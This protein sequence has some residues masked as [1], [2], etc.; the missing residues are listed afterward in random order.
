MKR[1]MEHTKWGR[2]DYLLVWSV[3][4]LG[5]L[6][7]LYELM[8]H[9]MKTQTF[10]AF[11][12]WVGLGTAEPALAEQ[13]PDP[14]NPVTPQFLSKPYLSANDKA[15]ERAPVYAE[16]A[17]KRD[18]FIRIDGYFLTLA[19][20]P[21]QPIRP[22]GFAA[23]KDLKT[24]PTYKIDNKF[25]NLTSKELRGSVMVHVIASR[26]DS[27]AKRVYPLVAMDGE[28]IANADINHKP[29]ERKFE[30]KLPTLRYRVLC[31]DGYAGELQAG[32]LGVGFPLTRSDLWP[33]FKMTFRP[34]THER[35]GIL[36]DRLDSV[37][38][39]WRVSLDEKSPQTSHDVS[40]LLFRRGAEGMILP[41]SSVVFDDPRNRNDIID[42]L[43]RNELTLGSLLQEY[44]KEKSLKYPAF[45]EG[46]AF[47]VGFTP[48]FDS[49]VP[50]IV[51]RDASPP[52]VPGDVDL[53]ARLTGD[54]IVAASDN[55]VQQVNQDPQGNEDQKGGQEIQPDTFTYFVTSR[56]EIFSSAPVQELFTSDYS[57][58]MSADGE[59][60]V[61]EKSGN[62]NMYKITC[63]TQPQSLTI[64]ALAE[65]ILAEPYL[66]D[67]NGTPLINTDDPDGDGPL[68]GALQT[69]AIRIVHTQDGVE[70]SELSQGWQEVSDATR[71]LELPPGP[72]GDFTGTLV[73]DPRTAPSTAPGL[74]DLARAI[75]TPANHE[76]ACGTDVT[77]ELTLDM[78]IA[79]KI[80]VEGGPCGR[81]QTV[82]LG[83]PAGLMPDQ[84]PV[85]TAQPDTGTANCTRFDL[86]TASLTCTVPVDTQTIDL[87]GTWGDHFTLEGHTARLTTADAEGRIEAPSI[88]IRL[89]P[90]SP[91]GTT[92]DEIWDPDIPAPA[93]LRY[94]PTKV[95]Y[96]TSDGDV[97]KT[98][99]LQTVPTL[100]AIGL[101]CE[102]LPTGI[103][104]TFIQVGLPEN[105][106]QMWGDLSAAFKGE[107]V[108]TVTLADPSRIDP[109]DV[110]K[111][112]NL[113]V[114][115]SSI[116]EDELPKLAGPALSLFK[117]DQCGSNPR[118]SA[119]RLSIDKN[120]GDTSGPVPAGG[121]SALDP[122]AH[123]WPLWGMYFTAEAPGTPPKSVSDCFPARIQPGGTA[124]FADGLNRSLEPGVTIVISMSRDLAGEGISRAT[125]KALEALAA[126]IDAEKAAGRASQLRPI[127]VL[128]I[129]RGGTNPTV[130]NGASNLASATEAILSLGESGLRTFSMD[131]FEQ[132][133]RVD[134]SEGAD[135]I[136]ITEGHEYDPGIEY[137]Y[138][139]LLPENVSLVLNGSCDE[140][141]R[142]F[143]ED[144]GCTNISD[145]GGPAAIERHL[146]QQFGSLIWG[147][148]Q[149][150]F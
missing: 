24:P 138:V 142:R 34:H 16:C 51:S 49:W 95:E 71:L 66:S 123:R 68:Q 99:N 35:M 69:Q 67:L 126:A 9:A 23:Y 25:G 105:P 119:W 10:I 75:Q 5:V 37:T 110:Y 44:Q 97:C 38:A 121:S 144:V 63:N 29:K 118:D 116:S 73:I 43:N 50:F 94:H 88:G 132:D 33:S 78:A 120:D 122:A 129:D 11:L 100:D 28:S 41:K 58:S 90:N 18:Q 89:F 21:D 45:L 8:S 40:P 150:L 79:G 42:R 65:I 112:L 14:E 128:K 92:V 125:K 147:D 148:P 133:S 55:Q 96:L 76:E 61:I 6:F 124:L 19:H 145:A 143:F 15:M 59:N 141:T 48:F 82:T 1:V 117:T 139:R 108:H 2:Y 27:D 53:A 57:T 47:S 102:A 114:N 36:W 52:V 86:N 103:K 81:T 149:K 22:A 84:V 107:Y 85:L 56:E 140:W 70:V 54:D 3:V 17:L 93:G 32:A 101:G 12:A 98:G 115:H 39:P 31:E 20:H 136:L 26:G 104:M 64:G 137:F 130:F 135:L 87:A 83:F 13:Q 46:L 109:A 62:V 106:N 91:Y 131:R 77:V 74:S 113:M 60:C 134:Q 146:K 4:A 80:L 7:I 30:D 127:E 111:P 72:L